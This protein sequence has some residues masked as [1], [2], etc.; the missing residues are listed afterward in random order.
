MANPAV[1]LPARSVKARLCGSA[2]TWSA[3]VRALFGDSE[4]SYVAQTLRD[5]GFSA[6]SFAS[7]TEARR[8]VCDALTRVEDG[9]EHA[10][11]DA[12]RSAAG[13]TRARLKERRAAIRA[14]RRRLEQEIWP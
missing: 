4:R 2:V 6:D 11:I 5:R 12:G 8:L 3:V 7:R 13:R 14:L 9:L 10:A 1:S